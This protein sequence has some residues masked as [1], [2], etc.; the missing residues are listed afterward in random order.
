MRRLNYCVILTGLLAALLP[1]GASALDNADCFTCHD[2]KTLTKKGADGK[3][4]GLFVDPAKYGA[5]V[6][7]TNA[8]TSCHGD[9][10]EAPH[11]KDFAAKTVSCAACHEKAVHSYTAS[12]HG[13]ARQ[14]GKLGAAVCADC[15]SQHDIQSPGA[16]TSPL[17]REQQGATCGKCHQQI[18]VEVRNS[19]HGKAMAHGAP[20]APTCTDCHADHQ[21]SGLKTVS[22]LKVA[23]DVCSRCHASE[24]FNA[25]YNLPVNRVTTFFSS[26]HGMAAKF[27]STR[28]ANC[29]SCHGYH[30]VLPSTDPRSS[31]NKANM[32]KTCQKC[33]PAA[34]ENFA[35]GTI[36]LDEN[37]AADI[38][39]RISGWVRRVYL[40]LIVGVIGSML[41]HNALVM[42][43]K[44]LLA[45]RR[46][47][48]TVVRMTLTQRLQHLLLLLSFIAL[49]LTG[50]A[51][52]YPD[53]WIAYL[54]GASENVRR[55]GHRAAAVVMLALAVY[56]TGYLLL[57]R[58]GRTLLREISPRLKDVFDVFAN[59]RYLLSPRAPQPAFARFGYAEKAE[60]WAVVWGTVIMGLTGLVIWFKM[61]STQWVPRWVIEV[62]ITV[63]YYEALLAVLAIIVWHFYH[64]FF[65]PDVYPNNTAWWDGRVSADLY[66]EEHPLD[67]ETLAAAGLEPHDQTV[68]PE[69]GSK[70]PADDAPD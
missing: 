18:M 54:L 67:H 50:F 61:T 27:G 10:T 37:S 38:G 15:H 69:D 17:R 36:H 9:I 29:A 59:L 62:A 49:A 63:H 42:I 16:P 35:F 28:S 4:T 6:H 14:A 48:L 43:R 39:S 53:G 21:I 40:L 41:V 12:I 52:K 33:H 32:V 31:V 56:H 65:D 55:L 30:N 66:R 64:V 57:T 13:V 70:T 20:D 51:L 8:C 34:N 24:R 26:Y 60:Y 1:R 5:S 68:A 11:P 7:A 22:P 47:E 58:E 3:V 25:R 45:R 2:D 44:I 19:I 46:R 23:E